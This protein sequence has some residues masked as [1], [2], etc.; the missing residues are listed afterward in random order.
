VTVSATT[1]DAITIPRLLEKHAVERGNRPA[2]RE[3]DL[4]IWQTY[5]WS[6]VSE[7]VEALAGGMAAL[8]FQRGDNLAVIGSNRNRLYWAMAAAQCLGDVPAPLYQDAVAQE[9]Y[10][11]QDA[12]IKFA[13]V[14]N[15]EQADKFCAASA[16]WADGA[17]ATPARRA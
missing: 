2:I 14:E 8:E 9:M 12:A 6:Q 11:L 5:T 4:G 16:G 3:R 15:Q 7:E 17:P 13:I 10:V 1:G